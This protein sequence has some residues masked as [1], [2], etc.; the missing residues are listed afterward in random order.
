VQ[1][2]QVKAVL[3]AVVVAVV[4]AFCVAAWVVFYRL[5]NIW[6]VLAV[7]A[8]TVC[9]MNALGNLIVHGDAFP[10]FERRR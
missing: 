6:V 9:A 7:V 10:D 4:V 3:L 1:E 8:A 5:T 2:V